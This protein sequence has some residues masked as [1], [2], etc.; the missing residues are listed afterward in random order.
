MK[1]V[2]LLI[3]ILALGMLLASCGG[4]N[5]NQGSPQIVKEYTPDWYGQAEDPTYLWAY[6][7][8]EKSTKTLAFDTA[9]ARAMQD[10]GQFVKTKVEAMTKVFEE[11][12]GAGDD[13]SV[14][15]LSSNVIR[16]LTRADFEGAYVS[17]QEIISKPNNKYEAF[18]QYSIPKESINKSTLDAIKNEKELYERFRASQAFQDLDEQLDKQK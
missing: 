5:K 6:G 11:E 2:A 4:G 15:A 9:K 13:S 7:Q 8:S 1:K 16:T 14:H 18:V 10:A 17:K 12:V 3:C